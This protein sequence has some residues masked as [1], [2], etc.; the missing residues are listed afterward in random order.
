MDPAINYSLRTLCNCISSV[1]HSPCLHTIITTCSS[2]F[3]SH[4]WAQPSWRIEPPPPS[5]PA[6]CPSKAGFLEKWLMSCAWKCAG[7]IWITPSLLCFNFWVALKRSGSW[8]LIF[9]GSFQLTVLFFSSQVVSSTGIL[10]FS[11]LAVGIPQTFQILV[12]IISPFLK[13]FCLL[14]PLLWNSVAQRK[15]YSHSLRD[16]VYSWILCFVSS[17]SVTIFF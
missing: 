10:L 14:S 5:C 8:T 15:T 17:F 12:T 11:V 6:L 16:P 3:R 13:G 7:G 1:S 9:A 4:R 2:C